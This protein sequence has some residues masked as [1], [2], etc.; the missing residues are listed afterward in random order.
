MTPTGQI[1]G[2][3]IAPPG[4]TIGEVGVPRP[5]PDPAVTTRVQ[6]VQRDDSLRPPTRTMITTE[7]GLVRPGIY[8]PV[9]GRLPLRIVV[10]IGENRGLRHRSTGQVGLQDKEDLHPGRGDVVPILA[11]RGYKP[12]A[13][14]HQNRSEPQQPEMLSYI[15][16]ERGGKRGTGPRSQ[17]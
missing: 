16:S 13:C 3:G 17:C 8:H 1:G 7:L 5:V 15:L 6:L 14:K 9:P 12:C 11:S 2:F 10:W 4:T